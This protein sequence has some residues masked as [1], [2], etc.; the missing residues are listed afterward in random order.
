MVTGGVSSLSSE[1]LVDVSGRRTAGGDAQ[2]TP[3][4]RISHH[5]LLSLTHRLP[6]LFYLLL[7]LV[8]YQYLQLNTGCQED[9]SVL[10]VL[11]KA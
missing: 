3:R 9:F 11:C 2:D 1:V 7:V 8:L 5:G 6:V 10:C 4:F